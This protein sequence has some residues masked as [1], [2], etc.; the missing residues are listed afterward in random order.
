MLP[1]Q[2][3]PAGTAVRS[4]NREEDVTSENSSVEPAESGPDLARSRGGALTG[5]QVG[6]YLVGDRLGSGGTASVYRA[7]DQ[8]QERTVALKILSHGADDAARSRFQLEARTVASLRHPHIVQTLQV[9]NAA[10]D[11]AA[12]IAMELVDGNSLDQLLKRR[13]RLSVAECC[14][15]LAPIAR[16]LD[17][18]H[19]QE[20]IH[21][22]VKPSNILLRPFDPGAFG[23]AA[24]G[25]HSVSAVYEA[26]QILIGAPSS[27]EYP[28]GHAAVDLPVA[29]LLSDFGIARALDMPELTNEGRTIGTPAYMA[30]EQCASSREVTGRAD[31]Y[32]LGAVLYRCLVGRPP[33]TGS[34]TQILHAHVYASL[35]LPDDLLAVLP[36]ELV[37]V[38]RRCLAKDPEERY[39]VAR[40]LADDLT[41]IAGRISSQETALA[42]QTSTLT[43]VSLPSVGLPP[44]S[45]HT[46]E[47]VIVTGAESRL[48]GVLSRDIPLEQSDGNGAQSVPAGS[49]SRSRLLPIMTVLTVL[50]IFGLLA[51]GIFVNNTLR[52]S[53]PSQAAQDPDSTDTQA[54]SLAAPE[55]PPNAAESVDEQVPA[56]SA[57]SP[58]GESEAQSASPLPDAA[59]KNDAGNCQYQI[60]VEFESYLGENSS[61]S[62][63]LGCP[64]GVPV[65]LAFETQFFQTG[66]AL[67]RLDKPIV[68]LHYFSN[69]EWEQREHAWRPGMPEAVDSPDLLSP[70]EELFQPVRGIGQIWAENLFV[71]QALG[72]ASAQ[73]VQANGILQSFEGGLLIY[74]SDLQDTISFLKSQ[75]RL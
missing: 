46:T 44:S 61:V 48:E 22:D 58:S 74:N 57:A 69:D 8:I 62:Q 24:A 60:A 38:M 45:S 6:R 12:Y 36:P 17:Y 55:Q 3:G 32:A 13:G 1:D 41:A 35:A 21:R 34:T 25:S 30:P 47:T 39:A 56:G 10:D 67:G 52:E 33:F 66:M 42:E 63:E 29:P 68:Y 23:S 14:N 7:Y 75:L 11:G 15:L 37:E 26:E 54:P 16:A 40:E 53:A 2:K 19:Q 5:R 70:A 50:L 73:P 59:V 51:A 27:G 4:E 20:I 18:A 28:V 9:G 65:L 49:S 71:R 31:I 72:W 64:K 43:L